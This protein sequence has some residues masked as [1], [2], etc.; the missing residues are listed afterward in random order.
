MT[1]S[2][3]A[4]KGKSKGNALHL[5]KPASAHFPIF[6]TEKLKCMNINSFKGNCRA[7]IGKCS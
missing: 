5:G 7:G 2:Y 6:L 3:Y 4:E 1:L